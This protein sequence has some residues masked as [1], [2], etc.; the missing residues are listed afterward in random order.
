LLRLDPGAPGT[1][2]FDFWLEYAPALSIL[3]AFLSR[4][5]CE[6]RRVRRPRQP[7]RLPF[8]E[9]LGLKLESAR[10]EGQRF[11]IESV[12]RPSEN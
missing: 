10:G 4:R 9:Q 2:K 3:L 6:P 7:S 12:E 11:V 1:G 8:Q 5:L